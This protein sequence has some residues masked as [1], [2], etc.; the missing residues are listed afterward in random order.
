MIKLLMEYGCPYCHH[1]IKRINERA[2]A[3]L[4]FNALARDPRSTKSFNG[5]D[6]YPP[7]ASLPPTP[8][9]RSDDILMAYFFVKTGLV[10]KE[11]SCGTWC[12]KGPSDSMVNAARFVQDSKYW[13]ALANR[14]I[15]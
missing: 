15:G 10:G 12:K 3:A 14:V 9:R 8:S 2:K 6:Y 7:M 1:T 4:A 5:N 13:T 11:K